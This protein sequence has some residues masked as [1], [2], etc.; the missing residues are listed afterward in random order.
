MGRKTKKL[1]ILNVV[2]QKGPFER[3]VI[4][5][6]K[7]RV[8]TGDRFS[9]LHKPTL[10]ANHNAAATEVQGIL[11]KSFGGVDTVKYVVP[12]FVE[13]YSHNPLE[14]AQVAE[15][16]SQSARLFVNTTE[17]GNGPNDSLVL[18]WIDWSRIEQ[19]KE[20]PNG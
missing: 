15:Y 1:P 4:E 7:N 17:N 18:S 2:E 10:F 6:N 14:V 12:L 5:D 19:M 9:K 13:V 8:W 11:K 20:F 3:Y 16:L